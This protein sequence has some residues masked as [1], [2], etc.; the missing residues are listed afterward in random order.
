VSHEDEALFEL[1]AQR[2]QAHHREPA[3]GKGRRVVAREHGLAVGIDFAE[4]VAVQI[5]N[6]VHG[7]QEG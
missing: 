3:I 1:G 4:V 2:W 6:G 5:T 7:N